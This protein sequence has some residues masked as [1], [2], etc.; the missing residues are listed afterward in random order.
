VAPST[1]EFKTLEEDDEFG[2]GGWDPEDMFAVNERQFGVQSTVPPSPTLPE[3]VS[4]DDVDRVVYEKWG[5]KRR[6]GANSRYSPALSPSTPP[7]AAKTD[8][9][10]LFH[11]DG[12]ILGGNGSQTI[13]PPPPPPPRPSAPAQVAVSPGLPLQA[14]RD[15]RFDT[16]EVMQVFLDNLEM[17]REKK[18]AAVRARLMDEQRRAA[19]AQAQAHIPPPP[20]PPN[21]PAPTVMYGYME[22]P[23][24]VHPMHGMRQPVRG[25]PLPHPAGPRQVVWTH[26]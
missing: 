20:P 5:K 18:R 17:R 4:I 22:H 25:R 10:A 23:S 2:S 15:F 19:Q 3:N 24:S 1:P 9:M 6:G 16:E 13:P 26:G 21:P 14:L 12:F 7:T 11:Q 8:L